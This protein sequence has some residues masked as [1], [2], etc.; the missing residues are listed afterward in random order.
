[1][2]LVSPLTDNLLPP[3]G[4]R[5]RAATP[6]PSV[7][8]TSEP[9]SG[10]MLIEALVLKDCLSAQRTAAVGVKLCSMTLVHSPHNLPWRWVGGRQRTVRY[11]ELKRLPVE[12]D[13]CYTNAT[14]QN[15][16]G[17]SASSRN[18]SVVFVPFM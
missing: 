13:R 17:V 7:V 9:G 2:L 15:Y 1:M 6:I 16:R 11:W 12:Q 4:M 18:I 3:K 5:S 8:A 14:K 10:P